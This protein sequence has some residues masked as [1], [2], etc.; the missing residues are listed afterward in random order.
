[1]FW[2]VLTLVVVGFFAG[3]IARALVPGRSHLTIRGTI[4]LGIAGSFLGGLLAY[5]IFGRVDD[6]I[7]Q[8]SGLFGSIVGSIIVLVVYRRLTRR[9]RRRDRA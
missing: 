7:V 5:V 2:Y 6:G 3:V 8:R 4:V 1:M 9:R